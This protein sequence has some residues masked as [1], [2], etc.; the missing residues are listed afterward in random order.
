MDSKLETAAH[1]HEHVPPDWYESS[2][3]VNIFQRYWHRRR[4]EE[5]G[6]VL[7]PVSGRVL[8]IGSADGFFTH[9]I[10]RRTHASEVIGIDVLKTSVAYAKKRYAADPKL[11]FLLADAHN[12]PFPKSHFSAVFCLEAMEHVLDPDVVL[13]QIGKV[14]K[15]GGYTVILVPSENILF[16][17]VW[18]FWTKWRGRIWTD[19]HLHFF[20]GGRL[21]KR[22]ARAGFT[23]V[24]SRTFLLG[25]LLLIKARKPS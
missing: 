16:K 20:S 19:T 8:D 15:P 9:E 3:R 23:R 10:A 18:F 25:M 4:F 5:V 7:E 6:R 13:S 17:I 2:V 24:E 22:I 21:E 1:L 14:L 12:L 11:K